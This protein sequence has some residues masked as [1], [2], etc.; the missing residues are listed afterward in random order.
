M[1]RSMLKTKNMPKEFWAEVVTCAVYLSNRCSTKSLFEQ[2]PQEAW[3]GRK[4]N[5]SHLRVFGS[6]GYVH[7]PDQERS[8]LDDKSKKHIFFGYDQRSK[9]Y[10]LYNPTTGKVIVSRDVEFDEEDNW[11]WSNEDKEKYDFLPFNTEDEQI[12]EVHEEDDV[13]PPHSP[14]NPNIPSSSS[15]SDSS[16]ETP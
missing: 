10:K 11:R 9:G 4:P 2:T 12:E 5:V 16:N 14:I 3:N 8:K 15:S 7:V 13:T 1:A 6:I